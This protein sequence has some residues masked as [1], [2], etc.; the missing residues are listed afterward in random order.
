VAVLTATMDSQSRLQ[1]TPSTHGEVS[2]IALASS[3][4]LAY[5]ASTYV[6]RGCCGSDPR[7][8]CAV[9]PDSIYVVHNFGAPLTGRNHS[10]PEQRA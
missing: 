2:D 5:A 3:V 8:S 1:C 10:K 4:T 9:D 7:K 6:S